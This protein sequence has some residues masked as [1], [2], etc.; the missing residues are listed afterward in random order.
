MQR[1]TILALAL[2]SFGALLPV[3][4]TQNFGIFEPSGGAG[5][6]TSSSTSTT[7]SSTGTGM[8][9]KVAADCDDVNPCTTDTCNKATGKCSNA[10]VPDGPVPALMDTTKDCKTDKCAGG[11]KTS[12][13]DDA[14][15]PDNMNPCVLVSCSMSSV[16]SNN[17]MQ[18]M[19]PG[20]TGMQKCDGMGN[21]IGCMMDGD[22]P[23]VGD[24][25][26]R[27]CN[28]M[29]QT[30]SPMNDAPQTGCNSNGGKVCDGLGACVHCVKD[31]DCNGP[32]EICVSSTCMSSCGDGK[33]NGTETDK[34][35][36][37]ACPKCD[38]GKNCNSGVDCTSLVCNTTCQAP[39]CTDG[40]QNQMESDKDCGGP[41]CPKCP[42]GKT[43]GSPG[44]CLSG[45]C[46][47]N[48][49]VN[50]CA[51]GVKDGNE[52]DKDCG[53]GMCNPCA[54]GKMC[55]QGS[56]CTSGFCVGN[57]CV[58][59]CHN[60]VKDSNETGIDCGGACAATCADGLGCNDGTDCTSAYCNSMNKCATPSCT[61]GAKNGME[62]DVDCG[63]TLCVSMSKTCADLLHCGANA[64]CTSNH[65][66][67][68]TCY[69]AQCF[70]NTMNG[71]ET[72][73]DCGGGAC[74]KCAGGLH[75]LTGADCVSGNCNV[76]SLKCM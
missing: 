64:D 60:G 29:A 62:T 40:V 53:G 19:V 72:D 10:K 73:K 38:N 28:T 54:N 43:C 50:H 44:D 59:A 61:D 3:A 52:T 46:I 33:T 42:D 14:D 6:S 9:C 63:G 16:V 4:C 39:T 36:G 22:C 18:G 2:L 68:G 35:C 30:C 21:C 75:C 70:D 31:G 51:D 71:T 56:D 37:G 25:Q 24:C 26:Q 41:N 76:G 17:V 65:C 11:T 58:D 20:C 74:P 1:S 23:M 12:V 67:S 34:D 7:T 27:H 5:G 32:P 15:V 55:A 13:A 69:Q 47:G 49:C 66:V 57:K 48:V 45:H 8:G